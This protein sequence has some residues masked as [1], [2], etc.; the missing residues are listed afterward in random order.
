MMSRRRKLLTLLGASVL[1][2]ALLIVRSSSQNRPPD[3]EHHH[4]PPWR[5][6]V[7]STQSFHIDDATVQVDFAPGSFDL[8]TADIMHWVENAATAVATYY[9]RFPVPRD[10]ILIVPTDDRHGVLQGT[11]WGDVGGSPAFTRMRLGQHTTVQEL[12]DDWM[13]THELVHTAFPSQEDAHHWIEEGIAVYVEPI[14]RVQA[15]FLK[16]EQ[17]WA[18]MVR[19]MPKGS[20]QPGDQGLDRTPTWGRTYWGGAQFCLLADVTI[21]EQTHN[22][23]GLEDALRAIVAAGGTIDQN[24][25]IEKALAAGDAGTGTHVL[26]DLYARMANQP[27]PVDLDAIWKDLGIVRTGEDQVSFNNQAPET[28]IRRAI[29]KT[30][31]TGVIRP[32]SSAPQ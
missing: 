6:P 1:G 15:G 5:S 32:Q 12:T 7:A 31:A 30:P 29:T 21:R 4:G 13:M 3:S 28:A 24:W 22:R 19:D 11:T 27:V 16:P 26:E 8:S 10:R 14:A 18:D 25:P 23:K 9:G 20:P 17:I 2:A